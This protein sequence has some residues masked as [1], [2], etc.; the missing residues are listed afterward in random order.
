MRR[1]CGSDADQC[2]ATSAAASEAAEP[3]PWK[4]LANTVESVVSVDSAVSRKR[5]AAEIVFNPWILLDDYKSD[6]K[7]R[8]RYDHRPRVR[9]PL[10][11]RPPCILVALIE[12]A[13]GSQ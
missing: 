8:H 6:K 3:S 13:K 4:L 10:M 7:P 5:S 11:H 9:C 2:S 12:V 1:G